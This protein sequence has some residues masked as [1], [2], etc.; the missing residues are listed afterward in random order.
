MIITTKNIYNK[1]A[2][3]DNDH[4]NMLMIEQP[5]QD[6]TLKSMIIITPISFIH[7]A[8]GGHFVL[9]ITMVCTKF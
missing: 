7:T 8:S 2:L 5:F 6:N 9:K 3:N 4:I 1:V